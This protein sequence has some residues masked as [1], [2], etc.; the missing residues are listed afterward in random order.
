MKTAAAILFI[1][2]FAAGG[3]SMIETLS[4]ERLAHGADVIVLVDII[5]V[6]S[7]GM[8]D[9]N[10]EVIANLVKVHEPLK[11][12]IAVGEELKI[13]TWRGIEDNAILKEGTRALLFLKS[14]DDHYTVFN[15][16]QGWWQLNE[17]GSFAGMGDGISIEQVKEAIKSPPPATST[18]VPVS[19]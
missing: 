9:K 3:Y 6:K 19:F 8:K 13:K 7:V 14:V 1:F 4:T 12:G 15:G 16:L 18:Y 10:L 2:L 17:D 11:G 5:G